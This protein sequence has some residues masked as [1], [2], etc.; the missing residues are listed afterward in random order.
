MS[1]E[2]KT[3]EQ[4]VPAAVPNGP[5]LKLECTE[6]STMCSLQTVTLKGDIEGVAVEL[7]VQL[8]EPE[9]HGCFKKHFRYEGV[10]VEAATDKGVEL[11]KAAEAIRLANRERAKKAQAALDAAF[12]VTK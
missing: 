11:E 10:L 1:D 8:H 6:V 9:T 3:Q 4:P 2:I 7:K 5:L 12:A